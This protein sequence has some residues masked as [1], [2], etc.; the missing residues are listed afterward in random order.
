MIPINL[1][2]S[3]CDILIHFKMPEYQMNDDRQIAAES[4]H[5]FNFYSLKL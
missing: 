4:Q 3:N 5:I 1:L 2:K